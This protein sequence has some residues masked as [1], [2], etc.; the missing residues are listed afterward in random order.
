[1]IKVLADKCRKLSVNKGLANMIKFINHNYH[2][3]VI[4]PLNSHYYLQILE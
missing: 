3:C 1:M 2:R 4:Q